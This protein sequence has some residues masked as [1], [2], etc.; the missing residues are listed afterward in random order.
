MITVVKIEPETRTIDITVTFEAIWGCWFFLD[1]KVR[2]C[3][4]E[5]LFILKTLVQQIKEPVQCLPWVIHV[6]LWR[7]RCSFCQVHLDRRPCD[8]VVLVDK[9]L[10]HLNPR[11][12]PCPV[13]CPHRDSF[14]IGQIGNLR[15]KCVLCWTVDYVRW[16]E[17]TATNIYR[18]VISIRTSLKFV[19]K[20]T[21]A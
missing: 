12:S 11:T 9:R 21:K 5:W 18:L 14:D 3:L 10:H 20:S 4:L 6:D 19:A 8:S 1:L 13:K 17:K 16:N 7:F 15:D 2:W